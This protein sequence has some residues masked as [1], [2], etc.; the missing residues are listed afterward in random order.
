MCDIFTRLI[1]HERS[2]ENATEIILSPTIFV[3]CIGSFI[4]ALV[5]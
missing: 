2:S 3:F 4:T 1:G 5:Q